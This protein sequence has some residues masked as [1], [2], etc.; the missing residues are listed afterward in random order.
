[1][2]QILVIFAT[3]FLAELA[4]KTQLA[5]LMFAADRQSSPLGVFAAATAAL[6]LSTALAVGLGFAAERYLAV[7]PL[8]LLAGCGFIALGL[9]SLWSYVRSA[10]AA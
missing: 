5:T 4:D 8:K 6:T 1:M 10:P 3:V 9:W 2:S 7:L